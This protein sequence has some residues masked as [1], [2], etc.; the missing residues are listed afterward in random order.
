MTPPLIKCSD[1]TK[2]YKM[3]QSEVR[4]LD[5][6]SLEI[7]QGEF[8]AIIGSSGSGKSTLMNMLGG[9]DK[10]SSGEVSINGDNLSTMSGKKLARFRNHT[11]G[12]VFQQFQLLP[13]KSA[14]KNV[15]LPLQYR[16]PKPD[17]IDAM[18]KKSLDM[19]G[20]A[21]R[22][23]HRPAELSGGQ[24]QRVA[25]ARALA[26]APTSRQVRWTVKHP[27]PS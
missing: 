10:P 22:A 16:R 7:A 19:V 27:K 24:Q 15:C 5:K 4:A 3:G 6:V 1:L 26:G 23:K 17:N 2:V 12:F 20:L 13:K 21:D 18:V 11:I 14:H 25:I 8:V 9:L